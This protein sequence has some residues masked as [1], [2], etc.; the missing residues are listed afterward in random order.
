MEATCGPFPVAM[1]NRSSQARKY[2]DKHGAV[3]TDKLD[4]D[5]QKH[6][7]RARPL[8]EV[9][10][11]PSHAPFLKLIKGLLTL[12]PTERASAKTALTWEWSTQGGAPG[13]G[14]EG[15]GGGD[16]YASGSVGP[17]SHGAAEQEETREAAP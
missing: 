11:A 14:H 5:S 4:R 10:Q 9:I 13:G 8:D 1:V 17:T 6:V 2:F 16:G 7:R 3:L 12:G 15:N